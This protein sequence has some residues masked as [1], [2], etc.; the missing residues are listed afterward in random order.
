VVFQA[1][2]NIVFI[3]TQ[4]KL[5]REKRISEKADRKVPVDTMIDLIIEL[6]L[7]LYGD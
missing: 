5:E 7:C 1:E 2:G 3:T 6:D 4:K